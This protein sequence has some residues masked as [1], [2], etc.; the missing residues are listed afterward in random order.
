MKKVIIHLFS[1]AL[2]ALTF[3]ANAQC[4]S[5]AAAPTSAAEA[6][7]G[8]D[9]FFE[10]PNTACPSTVTWTVQGNTGANLGTEISWQITNIQTGAIVASFGTWQNGNTG[11]GAGTAFST[12]IGPD[13]V[14]TVGTAYNLEYH[15]TFGDGFGAGG[16]IEILDYLGNVIT[17]V[18]GNFGTSGNIGFATP[19]QVSN[20]TATITTS[21]G[22]TSTPLVG[23]A[24][25]F[26]PMTF[27]NPSFCTTTTENI[28]WS[29]VC[30]ETSAVL[31]SGN[32]D[33]TVYPTVPTAAS[34]I[35]T[36]APTADGCGWTATPVGDCTGAE[37][38]IS[39][40]PAT[41]TYTD[42]MSGSQLFTVTYTG[43]SG[44]PDCC[45]VG[46]PAVPMTFTEPAPTSSA[47]A[48]DS[49]FN[50]AGTEGI[51]NAAYLT[52]GPFGMGGV[53]VSGSFTVEVAGYDYPQ[54]NLANTTDAG[55]VCQEIQTDPDFWVTIYVD[56]TLVSDE[57]VD[58][59]AGVIDQANPSAPF[60][61]ASAGGY[62]I[63]I[64]FAAIQAAGV[65]FDE[66]S[67]IEAYVYPNS[68]AG[69]SDPCGGT[70]VE[71]S[72][73]AAGPTVGNPGEWGATTTEINVVNFVFT[74]TQP[75]PAD[76]TLDDT[77]AYSCVAPCTPDAG[78]ISVG[79]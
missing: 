13:P 18:T 50:P 42:G 19:Q 32:M 55:G 53:A 14:A 54:V 16:I 20:V 24:S 26:E 60:G 5:Y 30:D 78:T 79:P 11:S 47:V 56:G 35:V 68:F 43:V 39:P 59:I 3:S 33:V 10:I 69:P 77:Q 41:T 22:V 46:G 31:S 23:C 44:G 38:T 58:P 36:I 8:V 1:L 73:Q 75:G 71:T 74:E 25:V 70:R 45:A 27:T 17:T 76:C 63:T 72:Y 62:S 65:T 15:D 21:A 49:P 6:C 51:N 64:D 2:V 34:D 29:L 48:T 12:T 61:T 37:Y 67:V 57:L 28:A 9:Y 52:T 7:S 66:N 4:P 40:D